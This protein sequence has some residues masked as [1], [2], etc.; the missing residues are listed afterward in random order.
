MKG[1]SARISPYWV[2]MLQ[3]SDKTLYTGITNDLRR[4]IREH[5]SGSASK[6]TRSR[7]PVS[8][9][10]AEAADGK[11]EALKRETAIKNMSRSAKLLL[12]TAYSAGNRHG[13]R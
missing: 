6:Y 7:R 9:V 12:S 5:N 11:S 2:Y 1:A 3:C 4:R 8:L 13:V 10:Y